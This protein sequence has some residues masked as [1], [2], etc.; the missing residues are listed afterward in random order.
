MFCLLLFQFFFCFKRSMYLSLYLSFRQLVLAIYL[1]SIFFFIIYFFYYP[2][3][4]LSIIS[5]IY[6]S[7]Y[8]YVCL[9]INLSVYP[10]IFRS[11]SLS[12]FIHP[13]LSKKILKSIYLSIFSMSIACMSILWLL[14]YKII[15]PSLYLHISLCNFSMLFL[16]V[17]SV[18]LF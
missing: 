16:P 4:L 8:L 11:L 12:L 9:L 7:I 13:S 3:L 6:Q 10:S 17:S 1:V 14:I 18:F 5:I 15:N 2:L